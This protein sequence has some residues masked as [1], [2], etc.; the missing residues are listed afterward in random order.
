MREKITVAKTKIKTRTK[1]AAKLTIKKTV[2]LSM[3]TWNKFDG[4]KFIT[5][6]ILTGAA[7][8]IELYVPV[9]KPVSGYL[10]NIGLTGLLVGGGHR[11]IKNKV[12]IKALITKV[13][14]KK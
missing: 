14:R 10:M 2:A 3:G 11:L 13:I 6:L 8:V 7:V 5:G 9:A 12:W 1:A 4:K